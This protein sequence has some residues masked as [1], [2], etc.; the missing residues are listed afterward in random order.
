MTL[1]TYNLIKPLKR[2]EI[3]VIMASSL[4]YV[5]CL[6]YFA[7]LF[8]PLL[9]QWLNMSDNKRYYQTQ[10]AYIIWILYGALIV[11]K[12]HHILPEN[13]LYLWVHMK[14]KYLYAKY[15]TYYIQ[16]LMYYLLIYGVCQ[17]IYYLAFDDY[18]GITTEA[19]GL[20]INGFVFQSFMVLWIRIQSR[21]TLILSFLLVVLLPS[22][23]LSTVD[24]FRLLLPF[25]RA[26]T[27][28]NMIE[29]GSLCLI[30]N[31]LS[32]ELQ[33]LKTN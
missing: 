15:A 21:Y 29:I 31:V 12:S 32:L 18:L 33:K 5:A 16:L 19:I 17:V 10:S 1:F 7:S 20:Y 22:L 27:T 13:E 2:F 23:D 8:D 25:N 3:I 9:D 28:K 24:A 6:L 4:F 26:I 14:S 30:Y 11:I